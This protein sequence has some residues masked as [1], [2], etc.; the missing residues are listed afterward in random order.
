MP[1]SLKQHDKVRITTIP[2]IGLVGIID[3]VETDYEELVF[4]V[5]VYDGDQIH[6]YLFERHELEFIEV[7]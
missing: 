3:S 6:N 2:F 4:S 1:E 7:H 5:N